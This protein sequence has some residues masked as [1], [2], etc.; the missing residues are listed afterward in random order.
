MVKTKDPRLVI[1]YSLSSFILHYGETADSGHYVSYARYNGVNPCWYKYD[2]QRVT[3]INNIEMELD[4]ATIQSS[5]YVF[6]YERIMPGGNV[7]I[8]P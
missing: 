7:R 5:A 3:K 1:Q 2:D 8:L 4:L 6:M